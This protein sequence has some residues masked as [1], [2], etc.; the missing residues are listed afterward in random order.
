LQGVDREE[1]FGRSTSLTELKKEEFAI[2]IPNA[3][4]RYMTL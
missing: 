3:I 1:E 4:S 2:D